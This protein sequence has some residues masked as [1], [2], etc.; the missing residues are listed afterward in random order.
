MRTIIQIKDG[1]NKTYYYRKTLYNMGFRFRKK[2]KIWIKT[3]EDESL[4]EYYKIFSK[5]RDLTIRTF[6]ETFE[7]S[8]DYRK[9]FFLSNPPHLKGKYFC[10]YCGTLLEL[11]ELTVDHI[12][13]VVK[14][15]RNGFSKWIL[16]KINIT[17]INDE[18]N[19]A[20]SC[21]EC[22]SRKGRKIGIWTI[23]GFLG[24]HKWFW[25]IFYVG[26]I[27]LTI[28]VFMAAYEVIKYGQ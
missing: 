23:R 13:P 26:F 17:D 28:L 18:R 5:S 6:R 14:A 12:I 1:K 9:R 27:C 3:D 20:C 15:Q 22:N 7:R 2:D 8:N 24:K 4:I 19:L 11:E 16:K 10:A 25:F 21:I